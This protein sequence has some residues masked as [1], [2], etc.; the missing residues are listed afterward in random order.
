MTNRIYMTILTAGLSFGLLTAAFADPVEVKPEMPRITAKVL[1][2][3]LNRDLPV[4][5]VPNRSPR[6]P[7]SVLGQDQKPS[8]EPLMQIAGR[9]GSSDYY[10][11]SPGFTYCCGNST[12]GYYCA[13]NVNGC[14]K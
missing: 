5:A 9:C 8:E 7:G 1:L 12:D 2:A 13:A 11:D 6:L 14:T 3:S 10:C 4:P